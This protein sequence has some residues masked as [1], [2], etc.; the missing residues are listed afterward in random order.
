MRRDGE[1]CWRMCGSEAGSGPVDVG[2]VAGMRRF[3][4]EV[5]AGSWCRLRWWG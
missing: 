5:L 4:V 1:V 3:G 2:E